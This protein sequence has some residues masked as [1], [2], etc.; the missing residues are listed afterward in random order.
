M[1]V[2]LSPSFA[3]TSADLAGPALSC[4][5]LVRARKLAEWVGPG[6]PLTSSGVLRP[7]DAAQAC[8]DLGIELPGPRLRSALDVE[9]LMQDW[10]TAAAAE[11]LEMDARRAW[12]APDLPD[13]ASSPHRD[14]MAILNA[15]VHAATAVMELAVDPCG[16]C[17]IVLHD[18][19]AAAGPLTIEQLASAVGAV[20]EPD[21]RE[22][23]PCPGCAQVHDS[24]DLLGFDD[25]LGDEGEGTEDHVQHVAGMATRLLA[26]GAADAS[27]RAVRLTP[28]GTML[29]ESVFQGYAPSPGADAATLISVISE[30]PPVVAR[31]VAQPWLSARIAADSAR[32]LLAFAESSGGGN[33][34][35]ALAFARELGTDAADAWRE[36]AK[37]PGFGAYGRQW[38]RMQ[39]ER[40]AEDA[41]DEAWM[42]VDTLSIMLDAMADVAPP[43]LVQALVAEQ[44]GEDAADAAQVML[45]SGH[46][47]A[48]EVAALLTGGPAVA[49]TG[50]PAAAKRGKSSS[51]RPGRSSSERGSRP[52][53]GALVYQLKIT[54]RGVSKPP[55]WRRVLVP[56]DVT[57]RDLHEVILRTMGWHGGHLH[58]FSTGWQE[59]GS[60]DP[61]LG[62][63]SDRKVR[64]SQVLTGPGDRLSY[65]YDFG[66][67]WEHGIVLEETRAAVP[68]ESYP[69]CVAARGACPPEDCGGAW[70][71]SDLKEILA[72]PSHEDHQDMLDWL[73][74]DTGAEF[75]PTEF[76]VAEVNARLG[77]FT[78]GR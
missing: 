1:A 17:L 5:A 76:S 72:N 61:D 65:T 64:L 13:P 59:Y 69:C 24:G 31:T 6:R 67:D 51:G 71:Y 73:G 9:E 38:L 26:F 11:F 18:L 56:A 14:P 75:N 58:V 66:D 36:W 16:G 3:T 39:G 2:L 45:R 15:W 47:R 52:E 77:T 22:G 70:G 29:A 44:A 50:G 57:L 60:P 53:S 42:A 30:L 43:L 8:R 46:P 62:H 74:L 27:E 63:A 35:A 32:E 20:L 55:V 12:A 19:H 10:L 4:A 48:S 37:R 23:A 33:R 25:L 68:G 34:I 78:R 21:E 28:L 7:T 54:L 49:A 40:V 41:A